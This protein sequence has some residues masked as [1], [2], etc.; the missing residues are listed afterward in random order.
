MVTQQQKIVITGAAG[1][2]GQ[3]LILYLRT[4]GYQN[5]IALDKHQANLAILK[6]LNPDITVVHA[7]LTKK[8][9]WEQHFELVDTVILLHAQITGLFQDDFIKN[10]LLATENVLAVIKCH[11]SAYTIHVSSSVVNTSAE[12]FYTA[13]KIAQEKMVL[14]SGI[15]CCVL[16]PTLMFGW[17]DPK[18][19]G[20]LS[21][22]M[23][24]TPFFPIPGHG[25]YIRQPLYSRDFCKIITA[26]MQKKSTNAI[27]EIVGQE[28][29]TYI[30]IIKSIK[31]AKSLNTMLVRIPYR[32][33]YWL[34]KCYALINAKPP[35]TADQLT[36]LTAGDYFTGINPKVVFGVS[37]TTLDDAIQET[38]THPVYSKIVLGR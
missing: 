25:E 27:Y 35:F 19:L 8:T 21:R 16:R 12:D 26:A 34:L 23:E 10:N 30:D 3:N 38:F 2:V 7:D 29:V 4:Q 5:I 1:L 6:K 33:F 22:F 36:A 24:K 31:K 18:H 28:Q 15:T 17:F 9:G 37:M 11:P 13:T 20:W 14:T 32:I